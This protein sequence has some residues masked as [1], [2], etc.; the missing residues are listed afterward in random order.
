MIRG[1]KVMLDR[2]LARLYGVTT[3]RLNEQDKRN[4]QRFPLDFMFRLTPQEADILRS[5]FA[6]SSTGGGDSSLRSQFV[7]SKISHGGR[8]YLPYAFT[9]DGVIMLA[10]VL[11]TRKAIQ[12]SIFVV[13]P[14]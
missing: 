12:T 7:T 10:A 3:K 14:A 1:Q 6:T 4:K 11:N 13:R 8:R 5:Q 9:E 2:D